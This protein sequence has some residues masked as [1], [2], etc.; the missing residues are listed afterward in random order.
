[1]RKGLIF[2]FLLLIATFSLIGLSQ[3]D[4]D[5]DVKIEEQPFVQQID[6]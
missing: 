6:K 1:M 4:P 3:D 5:I 2:L